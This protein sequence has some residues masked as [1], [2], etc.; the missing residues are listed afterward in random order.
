MKPTPDVAAGIQVHD[1]FSEW[2]RIYSSYHCFYEMMPRIAHAAAAISSRT[3][4]SSIHQSFT[5]NSTSSEFN[6][7]FPTSLY[8]QCLNICMNH[9]FSCS[10]A[11]RKALNPS[12][13]TLQKWFL[14]LKRW[15][16]RHSP[17]HFSNGW[18]PAIRTLVDDSW[19]MCSFITASFCW[20]DSES[21]WKLIARSIESVV[22]KESET[23]RSSCFDLCT[24]QSFQVMAMMVLLDVVWSP[25]RRI[26]RCRFDGCGRSHNYSLFERVS[27]PPFNY[28]QQQLC[29]RGP[30][31]VI[32]SII[33]NPI[34]SC[35]STVKRFGPVV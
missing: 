31:F 34:A 33:D 1:T 3:T 8:L 19:R 30:T 16:T 14:C 25:G 35:F 17:S 15:F 29:D 27:R 5:C 13:V 2:R 4:K 23:R 18:K 10:L 20:R 32:F 22:R 24:F 12:Y 21:W 26:P 7:S 28:T 6:F 9:S 11:H